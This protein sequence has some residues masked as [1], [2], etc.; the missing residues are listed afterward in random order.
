[1]GLETIR[2]GHEI[3]DQAHGRQAEFTLQFVGVDRP[4][5]VGETDA[6]TTDRTGETETRCPQ[7]EGVLGHELA[8][9][10]FEGLE[11]RTRLNLLRYTHHRIFG[12]VAY[13]KASVGSADVSGQNFHGSFLSSRLWLGAI[14]QRQVTSSTARGEQCPSSHPLNRGRAGCSR[15][16]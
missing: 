9:D 13:R 2:V 12:D 3:I 15:S 14:R 10:L 7:L 4:W 5:Q 1:Q 6:A 16:D 11:A 8:N